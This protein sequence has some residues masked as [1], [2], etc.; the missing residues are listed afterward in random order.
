MIQK[1]LRGY[2]FGSAL[3]DAMGRD[4]EFD[5]YKQILRGWGKDGM[6]EP[7]KSCHWTDD[8]QMMLAIADAIIE[9]D[10][11]DDE[12]IL[13]NT[14][15]SFV[16]WLRDPGHAPGGTCI[17]GANN[18]KRGIHW[19]ESGVKE[20]KGCGSVMRSGILGFFFDPPR[21]NSLSSKIGKM[22]HGHPTADAA[23][24]AGSLIISYVRDGLELD[25]CYREIREQTEGISDRFTELL[26]RSFW[27]ATHEKPSY[28]NLISIGRGWVA[29]EAFCMS[30]YCALQYE[31]DFKKAIRLAIN[32][33]GDSD[34]VGAI[35]GG[36]L[37]ALGGYEFVPPE[38]VRRLR[39]KKK[40]EQYFQRLKIKIKD[41]TP[42]NRN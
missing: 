26:D 13:E 28:E 15:R 29:E 6:L 17:K 30:Y 42:K 11:D 24:V 32:H 1:K 37:G 16:N 8:T 34:S 7:P 14:A 10:L 19:S 25:E 36:I 35:T 23:C 22:T 20:S 38:W 9:S 21:L 5:S 33:S 18:L 41:R 31:N 3:G 2:L 27:L 4:L 40:L 12:L 39:E